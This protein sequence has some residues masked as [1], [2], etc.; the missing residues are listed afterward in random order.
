MYQQIYAFTSGKSISITAYSTGI[1]K[2]QLIVALFLTP[3][4]L[5]QFHYSA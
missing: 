3:I 2:A 4:D 5:R 1:L